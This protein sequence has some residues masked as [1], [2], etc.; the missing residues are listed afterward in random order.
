MAKILGVGNATLDIINRVDG[1]PVEDS[2]NKA[3]SQRMALGGNTAN[4]LNVLS[5]LGH[6]CQFVGVLAYDA[7]G[8]ALREALSDLGIGT[9]HCFATRGQ[10]P[11][12]YITLNEQSGSRTIVHY[13][14]L[15]ELHSQH[16]ID[17]IQ[18]RDY[19]WLHL[20]ARANVGDVE[21]IAQHIQNDRL[22]TQV[23]S[24]E[25]EKPHQD[26]ERLIP[27]ADVVF[28]SKD[29]ARHHQQ[30]SPEAMLDFS[31]VL[32]AKHL[33]VC[34]WGTRGAWAENSE[35]QRFHSPAFPPRQVIDTVGAGDTY[36]GGFID[37]Q[38]RGLDVQQSLE[39]ACRLAG[40]K[41]GQEGF[42]HLN[43]L[44]AQ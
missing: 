24:I 1:Y 21:T 38:C 34:P 25:I 2:E 7:F 31:R 26:V 3:L 35:G 43:D 5:Q 18:V 32:G 6:Q 17:E 27:L 16:F 12:S 36:N 23:I 37:A 30:N 29:F 42:E 11:T 41:V 20:Q 40:K 44:E 39:Q 13:R 28:F 10:T 19:A 8:R 15:P 33:V 22:E 14:D 9:S 4:T